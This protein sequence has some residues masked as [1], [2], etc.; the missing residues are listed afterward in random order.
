MKQK[1]FRTALS[2]LLLV[3]T[4]LTVVPTETFLFT[5]NADDVEPDPDDP[6]PEDRLRIRYSHE[7]GFYNR[8]FELTLTAPEGATIHYTFSGGDAANTLPTGTTTFVQAAEETTFGHS[9]LRRHDGGISAYIWDARSGVRRVV[10]VDSRARSV[11]GGVATINVVFTGARSAFTVSAVAERD[12]EFSRPR[13]LTYIRG[14][15]DYWAENG[16]MIFSLHTDAEGIFDFSSGIFGDGLIRLDWMRRYVELNSGRT[17]A[18]IKG[19][20]NSHL[21]QGNFPPT[22][23]ANFYMRGRGIDGRWV[24]DRNCDP[25]GREGRVAPCPNAPEGCTFKNNFSAAERITDLEVFDPKAD[26][27]NSRIVSQRV[28]IRVKGGWSRGT[29][30]NEQKTFEIYAREAYDSRD[31]VLAPIFGEAHDNNGNLMHRYRR[32]RLR[33]GGTDREQMYM[34]D[35]LAY[36]LAEISGYPD[37]YDYT[38]AV[39]FMNGSYYGLV[40]SRTP[41]TEDHFRRSY[42]DTNVDRFKILGSNEMGRAGC[43]ADNRPGCDRVVT[44]SNAHAN[45][46]SAPVGRQVNMVSP[47][48]A[49]HML[50]TICGDS[51]S[52]GRYMMCNRADCSD[53][54]SGFDAMCAPHNRCIG[55]HGQGSWAEVR[56][57]AMG[58]TIASPGRP[59]DITATTGSGLT[60]ADN[61][62]RFQELVDVDDLLHY[63]ALNI[64]GANV[65]W[66]SNN[67]QMWRY[68]P[69][70]AE[71]RAENHDPRIRDGRWRMIAHDMEFGYGLWSGGEP[72]PSGTRPAINTLHALINR[73]GETN[74]GGNGIHFNANPN[75][76]WMMP[77]ILQRPDMRAKLANIFSD[78]IDNSHSATTSQAVFTSMRSSFRDEHGHMLSIGRIS[79]LARNGTDA[80]GPGWPASLADVEGSAAS[81]AIDTFLAARGASM[82]T[83]IAK[84]YGTTDAGL[85]MPWASRKSTSLAIG[86]GGD[87][88]LNSRPGGMINLK[89]YGTVVDPRQRPG[90]DPAATH[91]ITG[92]YFDGVDIPCKANP[93]PGYEVDTWTVNGTAVQP[94][95]SELAFG[96]NM[97]N[98]KAGDVVT[99]TFKKVAMP[100]RNVHINNIQARRQNWIELVNNGDKTIST[101]G[102]FLSDNYDGVRDPGTG[103][104]AHDLKWKMPVFILEPGQKLFIRT[105]NYRGNEVTLNRAVLERPRWSITFGERLRLAD[106]TGRVLQHVDVSQMTDTQM[107]QRDL[108]GKWHIVTSRYTAPPCDDCDHAPCRCCLLCGEFPCVCPPCPGGCGKQISNCECCPFTVKIGDNLVNKNNYSIDYTITRGTGSEANIWSDN[109]RPSLSPARDVPAFWAEITITNLGASPLTGLNLSTLVPAGTMVGMHNR[110]PDN[111][112]PTVSGNTLTIIGIPAVGETPVRLRFRLGHVDDTPEFNRMAMCPRNCGGFV[113]ACVLCATCKGCPCTCQPCATCSNLPASC[114]CQCPRSCGKLVRECQPGLATAGCCFVCSPAVRNPC[115]VSHGPTA[116]VTEISAQW[117]TQA[118]LNLRFN[119]PGAATSSWTIVLNVPAGTPNAS[120]TCPQYNW[121]LTTQTV[122]WAITGGDTLTIRSNNYNIPSGTHNMQVFLETYNLP[123]SWNTSNVTFRSS[124]PFA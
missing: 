118:L 43:G 10:G 58:G 2:M 97:I 44:P 30:M 3:A 116:T 75:T 99:V 94:V 56:S 96:R 123:S 72:T 20:Q 108:S 40:W 82:Q 102:L 95:A 24:C 6:E 36:K 103:I 119:N 15:Q 49:T 68:F 16:F 111:L 74:L 53:Y 92:M 17:V 50:P 59:S 114:T 71:R 12:G 27:G 64:Y 34:R 69:T 121:G 113:G 109:L 93:W 63:Y 62:R 11:T 45:N 67:I 76:S 78:L 104:R 46:P 57:L 21:T 89:T 35:E 18:W 105:D 124:G 110:T 5:V 83:H 23:P 73:T 81:T 48:S 77:A 65:D 122:T 8:N 42:P 39:V 117:G 14:P 101:K 51:A 79:E 88:V 52:G 29:F 90:N 41:R 115:G 84:A 112:N 47:A 100:Q 60:N 66:P 19:Q 98:V 55:V 80:A 31:N 87:A 33:N 91:T 120:G 28:G 54:W 13:T 1:A 25:R 38:P 70:A 86:T 107:Q 37:T 61:W 32:F 4:L 7:P 26:H 85:G 9:A 106:A 22:L